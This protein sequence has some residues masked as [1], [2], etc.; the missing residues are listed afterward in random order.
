MG[1][2]AS[3][4]SALRRRLTVWLVLWVT[5]LA[6]LAPAAT[7]ALEALGDGVVTS[8]V[9]S[10][11]KPLSLSA[12]GAPGQEQLQASEHCS[13]CVLSLERAA[14]PSADPPTS[15][16]TQADHESALRPSWVRVAARAV[17]AAAPRGPPA[18]S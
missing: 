10:A 14:P 6:A 4:L 15:V 2:H 17:L 7:H 8:D 3:S 9:C 16:P 18:T 13:L 12:G 5:V 1:L 11:S